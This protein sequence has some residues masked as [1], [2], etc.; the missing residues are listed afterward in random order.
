MGAGLAAAG[1]PCAPRPSVGIVLT[2]GFTPWAGPTT[3]FACASSSDSSPR[4][5]PPAPVG[6][7]RN[8]HARLSST[9]VTRGRPPNAVAPAMRHSR[10]SMRGRPN[11][12]ADSAPRRPERGGPATGVPRPACSVTVR[13]PRS[14]LRHHRYAARGRRG[15]ADAPGRRVRRPRPSSVKIRRK[16]TIAFSAASRSPRASRRRGSGRTVSWSAS[17]RPSRFPCSDNHSTYATRCSSLRPF[18]IHLGPTLRRRP[19]PEK[20]LVSS[21]SGT[22]ER[23]GLTSAGPRFS[24]KPP[25]AALRAAKRLRR[26]PR[27]R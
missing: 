21:S 9:I 22:S 25:T 16:R 4:G 11:Q 1:R 8:G 10:W 2:D 5:V 7:H 13:P 24:L 17:S 20:L 18:R 6:H 19:A 14:Q 26:T 23:R 27:E 15:S 3:G 12:P